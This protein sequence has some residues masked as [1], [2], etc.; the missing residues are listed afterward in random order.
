MRQL[1]HNLFQNKPE[2]ELAYLFG[3]KAKGTD[4]A[5]SDTDIALLLKNTPHLFDY[6]LELLRE[7]KQI[8]NS[9]TIDLV[10]LNNAPP[11]LRYQAVCFGTM[12]HCKNDLTPFHYK[13]KVINEYLDIKPML[14][15]F[16]RDA[17]NKI[18][19]A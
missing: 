11:L 16:T 17:I 15:F 2:I 18:R 14:D 12:I 19:K 3:S 4:T 13:A 1:L 9:D 10:I 5:L 6:K 8:L 7:I